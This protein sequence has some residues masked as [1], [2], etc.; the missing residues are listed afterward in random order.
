MTREIVFHIGLEKTGT[1][2]FQRFCAAH[3]G[4]LARPRGGLPPLRAPRPGDHPPIAGR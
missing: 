3:R 4:A 2:A 1:T